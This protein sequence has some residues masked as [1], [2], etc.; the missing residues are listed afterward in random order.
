MENLSYVDSYGEYKI[1]F[2]QRGS[3]KLEITN[4]KTGDIVLSISFW[5]QVAEKV[6]FDNFLTR[7][8]DVR[9]NRILLGEI[10]NLKDKYT[11]LEEKYNMLFGFME[12][13]PEQLDKI[14]AIMRG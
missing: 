1:E 12:L 13:S 4:T 3:Y 7:W 10:N 14:K 2:P 5:R 6:D 9:N 11:T 8:M